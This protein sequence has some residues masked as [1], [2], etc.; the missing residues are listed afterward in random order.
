M[1]IKLLYMCWQLSGVLN[2]K[3]LFSIFSC[4]LK[5]AGVKDFKNLILGRFHKPFCTQCQTLHPTLNFYTTKSFLKVGCRARNG[6]VGCKTVHQIDPWLGESTSWYAW[7]EPT[8]LIPT[9]TTTHML[10]QLDYLM[11]CKE[12]ADVCCW[13]LL[14]QLQMLPMML[15]LLLGR[16][17]FQFGRD[18]QIPQGPWS[19][20]I[21]A[22]L[23][24]VQLLIKLPK[25]KHKSS[26]HMWK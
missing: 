25:R 26:Q 7:H 22:N 17:C 15:L 10:F 12:M 2:A 11:W 16:H 18:Y 1:G 3:T 9:T 4:W 14:L 24:N 20:Q 5:N 21:N 19:C 8:L 13:L 23:E 6:G